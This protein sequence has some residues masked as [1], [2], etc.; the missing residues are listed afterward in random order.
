MSDEVKV[1][2]SVQER[3]DLLEYW[4]ICEQHQKALNDELVRMLEPHPEFGPLIKAMSPA[5]QEAQNARSM[6]L[7]R[8]AIVGGEWA[9]Y[10]ANLREQGVTYA[11]MG[12]SFAG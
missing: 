4:Q 10:I 6:E 1:H 11:K 2:L 3:A 5:Q 12:I 8:R 9:P 7:Q